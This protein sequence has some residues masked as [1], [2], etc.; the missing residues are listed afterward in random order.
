[1][2]CLHFKIIGTLST[3]SKFLTDELMGL[4]SVAILIRSSTCSM[5]IGYLVTI[6]Y[7]AG[8]PQ[9]VVQVVKTYRRIQTAVCIRHIDGLC[10]ADH[11]DSGYGVMAT[12]KSAIGDGVVGTSCGSSDASWSSFL[13]NKREV[14]FGSVSLSLSR[15]YICLGPFVFLSFHK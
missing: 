11:A 4:I 12:V 15:L 8:Q 7:Q 3:R 2:R 13:P 1:M 9:Q 5:S 14:W 6:Y 10:P